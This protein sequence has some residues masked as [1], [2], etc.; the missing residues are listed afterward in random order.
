VH[1]PVLVPYLCRHQRKQA[2]QRSCLYGL[3]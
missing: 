2:I 1:D 3:G